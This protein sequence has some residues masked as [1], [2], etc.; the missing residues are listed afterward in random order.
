MCHFV[1]QWADSETAAGVYGIRG[2]E[3]FA[4]WEVG[5][6]F[7]SGTYQTPLVQEYT[8]TNVLIYCQMKEIPPARVLIHQEP[9]EEV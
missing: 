7:T 1:W 5:M 8:D 3:A 2:E 9:S 4:L 6:H